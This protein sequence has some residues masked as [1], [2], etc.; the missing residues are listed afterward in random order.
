MQ[1]CVPARSF[2]R[3]ATTREMNKSLLSIAHAERIAA[4]VRADAASSEPV[5]VLLVEYASIDSSQERVQLARSIWTGLAARLQCIATQATLS[6]PSER[7]PGFLFSE[8]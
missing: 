2:D 7:T 4:I 1:L 5:R 8:R 6:A 3:R